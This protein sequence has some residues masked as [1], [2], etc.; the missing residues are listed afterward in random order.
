VHR[1]AITHITT[2]TRAHTHPLARQ[3]TR[4]CRVRVRE[5][6][7]GRLRANLSVHDSDHDARTFTKCEF[8]WL[9]C[10]VRKLGCRLAERS[11]KR[12]RTRTRHAI[13]HLHEQRRIKQL[14]VVARELALRAV[15]CEQCAHPPIERAHAS[16]VNAHAT[17]MTHQPTSS[18]SAAA[19]SSSSFIASTRTHCQRQVSCVRVHTL[20]TL[21]WPSSMEISSSSRFCRDVVDTASHA[22]AN[23]LPRMRATP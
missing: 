10:R 19:A 13:S 17:R 1:I 16:H 18:L 9:A 2:H 20:G 8:C 22:R 11:V 23:L 5:S 3:S 12:L 4:R 14:H 21:T 15:A 7:R 6:K